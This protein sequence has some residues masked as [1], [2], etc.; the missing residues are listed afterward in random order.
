MGSPNY[1]RLERGGF[2]LALEIGYYRAASE[3]GDGERSC[4]LTLLYLVS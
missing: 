1:D 3:R 4:C 2:S